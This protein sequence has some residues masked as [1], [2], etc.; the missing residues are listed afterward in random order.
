MCQKQPKFANSSQK[1]H[2]ALRRTRI[3]SGAPEWCDN[4]PGG[5]V[6]D[7][8]SAGGPI[9]LHVS[10]GH[11][12]RL[13]CGDLDSVGRTPHSPG[14]VGFRSIMFLFCSPAAAIMPK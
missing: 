10:I 13:G 4:S 7:R 5:C 6:N 1:F 8:N 9:G 3:V 12:G 2:E 11:S 14:A